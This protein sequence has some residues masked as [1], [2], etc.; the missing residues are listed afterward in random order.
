MRRLA[1]AL[2]FAFAFALPAIGPETAGTAGASGLRGV[3]KLY[4]SRPVCDEALPCTKPA[5]NTL[6]VFSRGGRALARVTTRADGAY[7]IGLPPGTYAVAAPRYRI[8][9]GVTPRTVR[10]PRGRIARVDLT[11]DTGIQ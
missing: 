1:L 10:V 3:V 4:P 7:R 2:A 6:L 11:I 8:G 5:A 9:S